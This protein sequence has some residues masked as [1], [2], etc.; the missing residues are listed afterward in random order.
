LIE[1]KK[2]NENYADG[3]ASTGVMFIQMFM[4]I[5]QMVPKLLMGVW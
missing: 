4:E 3:M 5:C 2:K 1:K